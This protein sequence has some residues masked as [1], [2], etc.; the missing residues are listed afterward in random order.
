MF[1]CLY[2]CGRM[3]HVPSK[4]MQLR[5]KVLKINFKFEFGKFLAKSNSTHAAQ[6]PTC[7]LMYRQTLLLATFT[8]QHLSFDCCL[9]I[10]TQLAGCCFWLLL[11]CYLSLLLLPLPKSA[12]ICSLIVIVFVIAVVYVNMGVL[13]SHS[14][15]HMCSYT[16][17][18]CR[19]VRMSTCHIFTFVIAVISQCFR[20]HFV[21][22][23]QLIQKQ[24]PYNPKTHTHLHILTANLTHV[25]CQTDCQAGC[26]F[27]TATVIS[28][29]ARMLENFC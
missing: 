20:A 28:Q 16:K 24:T 12:E 8:R 2:V 19:N 10:V 25:M 3:L 1:V 14:H 7:T 22:V 9:A 6:P 21:G 26:L 17:Y 27:V 29:D 15:T 13:C 4:V 5:H 18:V 11:S 23:L